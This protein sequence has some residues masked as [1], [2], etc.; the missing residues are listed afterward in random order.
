VRRQYD[1]FWF[2]PAV[3][4][5]IITPERAFEVLHFKGG[6]WV[7]DPGDDTVTVRWPRLELS[8]L[9]GISE[10]PLK[11]TQVTACLG[12]CSV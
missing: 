8:D 7:S 5:A 2:P 10:I 11:E 3:R 4:D 12:L 9:S 1:G 6:G